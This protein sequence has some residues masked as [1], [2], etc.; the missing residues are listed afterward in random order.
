MR[1]FRFSSL[2]TLAFILF[3]ATGLAAG[4]TA[5]GIGG[6]G[7]DNNNNLV[8]PEAGVPDSGVDGGGNNNNQPPE[9]Q[10]LTVQQLRDGFL[11]ETLGQTIADLRPIDECQ[12]GHIPDAQCLPLQV[13][14]DGEAFLNGGDA[15]IAQTTAEVNPLIFYGSAAM[16]ATVLEVAEASIELGY[17]DV[18]VVTGGI[19]AWRAE[20]WYE[21][22]ERHGILAH[23][24]SVDATGYVTIP[25]DV[26]I[27]DTM[28]AAT[29]AADGHISCAININGD[30]L[31]YGGE[32]QPGAEDLLTAVALNKAT[33]VFIFY[34]VN[35]GCAASEAA[36]F[37]AEAVGYQNVY[38]Y[39]EGLEDWEGS[40]NPVVVDTCACP[41]GR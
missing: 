1:I 7:D 27:V 33:D 2:F 4:L 41:C 19:E 17:T 14:W 23:Y 28:D 9:V 10:A 3:L 30:D 22:I 12:A 16:D 18:Y 37:A 34:C 32:L 15:L 8:R 36:S 21:D 29:Y 38:H 35:E 11:Y 6:P 13:L 26:Y 24:Y 5:C 40:A 31:W 20:A 25:P 39:K